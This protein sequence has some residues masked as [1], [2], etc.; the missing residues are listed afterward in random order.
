MNPNLWVRSLGSELDW[1]FVAEANPGCYLDAVVVSVT[2]RNSLADPLIDHIRLAIPT[3]AQ[4]RGPVACVYGAGTYTRI[5]ADWD[6]CFL[7]ATY[8]LSI[9]AEKKPVR[10]PLTVLI[11][12]S[13]S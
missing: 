8:S 3:N 1:G 11:R 9:S 6:S 12:P 4:R 2:S 7:T 5:S 13:S 10:A